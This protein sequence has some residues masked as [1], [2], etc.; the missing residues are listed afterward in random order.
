VH[1]PIPVLIITA[2]QPMGILSSPMMPIIAFPRS[3]SQI[4]EPVCYFS[5]IPEE[6]L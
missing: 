1:I 5:D 2:T 4:A 3:L 6:I